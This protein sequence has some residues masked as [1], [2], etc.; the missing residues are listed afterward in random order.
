MEKL[1]EAHRNRVVLEAEAESESLRLKGEAEA[2]AIEAKAKAESD[3]MMKKAEAWKEYKEA[4][5]IDMVLD[6]LPK[7]KKINV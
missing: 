7:V 2:F 4:A 3:Q 6:V 5:M 1:A